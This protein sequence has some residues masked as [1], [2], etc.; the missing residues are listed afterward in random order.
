MCESLPFKKYKHKEINW[1]PPLSDYPECD[2][3]TAEI[4]L[5]NK[6]YM[7]RIEQMDKHWWWCCFYVDGEMEWD[8]NEH[9]AKTFLSARM[10]VLRELNKYR[11]NH[12]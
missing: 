7:L 3:F 5:I 11:Y 1:D 12:W 2:D 8:N 9:P 4:K 6:T 10:Q